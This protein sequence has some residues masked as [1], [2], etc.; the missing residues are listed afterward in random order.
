MGFEDVTQTETN[1]L[2]GLFDKDQ[3]GTST[4]P[5][6]LGPVTHLTTTSPRPKPAATY[7]RTA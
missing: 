7:A 2:F 1:E 5:P 6:R 4:H 3:G